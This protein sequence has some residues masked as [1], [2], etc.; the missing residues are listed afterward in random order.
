LIAVLASGEA[1]SWI[2]LCLPL[3]GLFGY[4]VLSQLS[5]R[6]H[7]LL[8]DKRWKQW[9]YCIAGLVAYALVAPMAYSER[10]GGLPDDTTGGD[11]QDSKFLVW[12]F[13]MPVLQILWCKG[14]SETLKKKETAGK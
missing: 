2:L 14:V 13:A 6:T 7:W 4:A 9:V 1:G 10:F 3:A 12:L 8:D 11:W 5:P